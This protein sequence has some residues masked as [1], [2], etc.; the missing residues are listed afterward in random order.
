[1]L[2]RCPGLLCV[3]ALALGLSLGR[4]PPAPWLPAPWLPAFTL[5]LLGALLLLWQARREQHAPGRSSALRHFA[6]FAL[7]LAVG[8]LRQPGPAGLDAALLE[9]RASVASSGSP[10]VARGIVDLPAVVMPSLAGA[11][12]PVTRFRLTLDDGTGATFVSCPGTV[13]VRGGDAVEVTGRWVVLDGPRNPGDF[14]TT[15]M[16][17]LH[18][19]DRDAVITLAPTSP[20]SLPVLLGRV[21]ENAFRTLESLYPEDTRGFMIAMLLGDRRLL[22][23]EI[24]DTLLLTG[25]YHLL[26]ISGLH[27][28]LLMLGLLR[29]PLPARLRTPLRLVLL[30]L[31]T[32]LTGASPP[33]LRSA[34]MFVLALAAETQGR[35]AHPLNT[36]GWSAGVLLAIDPEL[37]SDLGFELSFV[38]VAALLTW[39]SRLS[40]RSREWPVGLRLLG[41]SLAVSLGAAV[42]TAPLVLYHFHRLHPTGPLW[43]LL[44]FPL[45]VLPLLGGLA[46]LL[47][48]AIHTSLGAGVAWAVDGATRICLWPLQVGAHWPGSTVYLP[49]PPAWAVLASYLILIGGLAGGA[50]RARAIAIAAVLALCTL[51][52]LTRPDQPEI[53]TF[54]AGPGDAALLQAPGLGALLIDAGM[55]GSDER[56]GELLV[57]A[58]LAVGARTL[59]GAFITHAHADHTRGLTGVARRLEVARIW[60]N[61]AV[62][63]ENMGVPIESARRGLRLRTPGR[64]GRPELIIEVLYPPREGLGTLAAVN[65]A[66]LALRLTMGGSRFL[67]LGDLEEDGIAGLLCAEQDLKADVLLAPHHGRRNRLWAELCARAQPRSVI[68]SGTGNGGARELALELGQSGI[69]VFP[70]WR[71][72]AIRTSWQPGTGWRPRPWRPT[73]LRPSSVST[74]R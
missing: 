14:A 7:C 54:D 4:I 23:G 27:V 21:R 8:W 13:P 42:G 56:A 53:W 5:L 10:V 71:L 35:R 70:T 22:S 55:P 20:F 44:A 58:L 49:S 38:S 39:G 24:N 48:A 67:F 40:A 45:T 59:N 9:R 28:T 72:G 57:R 68:I 52:W 74:T 47:A 60:A 29:L 73:P 6:R 36:L 12:R 41:A 25:T 1:M 61:G 19:P 32:L 50:G 26:A 63:L 64:H 34:L 2:D 46:T 16:W 66:S 62:A 51:S 15:E 37:L 30:G 18:A 31:F 65:D 43:N 17:A 11:H 3:C 33:V 69:E